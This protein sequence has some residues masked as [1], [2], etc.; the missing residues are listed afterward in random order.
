M[1]ED[2]S[3]DHNMELQ[4]GHASRGTS[5]WPDD[6]CEELEPAIDE[7]GPDASPCMS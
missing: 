1:E 4:P 6:R 5:H 3:P 7:I 2:D